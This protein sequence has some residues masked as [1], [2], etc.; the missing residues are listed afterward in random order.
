MQIHDFFVDINQQRYK[1]SIEGECRE[2]ERE[3]YRYSPEVIFVRTKAFNAKMHKGKRR[4]QSGII[5][6]CQWKGDKSHLIGTFRL[7]TA[8]HRHLPQ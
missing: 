7:E 8:D 4:I 3:L 1:I 6:T 2:I 5:R